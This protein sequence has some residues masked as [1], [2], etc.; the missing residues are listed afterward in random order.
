MRVEKT[1]HPGEYQVSGM[2]IRGCDWTL[3]RKEGVGTYA[4]IA[5]LDDSSPDED[6]EIVIEEEF[7]LDRRA[8]WDQ[9]T[10][11]ELAKEAYLEIQTILIADY[12]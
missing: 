12:C 11:C 4:R 7:A 5:G 10:L 9:L 1:G 6:K 8:L 2:E 3:I